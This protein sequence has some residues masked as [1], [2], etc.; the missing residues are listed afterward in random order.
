MTEVLATGVG[1]ALAVLCSGAR[2]HLLRLSV[3]RQTRQ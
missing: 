1:V 2:A 3:A